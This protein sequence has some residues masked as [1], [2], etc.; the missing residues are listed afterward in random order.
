MRPNFEYYMGK[1]DDWPFEVGVDLSLR[2]RAPIAEK[3]YRIH[4]RFELNGASSDGLSTKEEDALLALIEDEVIA[5]LDPEIYA[6]VSEV[7]HRKAR[8][9]VFYSSQRPEED[10]TIQKALD[11]IETHTTKVIGEEDPE[12]TEYTEVLYPCEEMMHQ[13][14]DKRVLRQFER[15]GDDSAEVRAIEPR[16]I[17]LN[18]ANAKTLAENLRGQGYGIGEIAD[19]GS[20]TWS[21][22]AQVQSPLALAILDDFRHT[23]LELARQHEGTYQGWSAEVVP[24]SGKNNNTGLGGHLNDI[25]DEFGLPDESK[26]SDD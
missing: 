16:F 18:E 6:F 11:L 25:P 13:I 24:V 23:W 8:T 15:Q 7:T 22:T 12:W 21:V 17:G 1:L 2:E 14:Q 26:L 9:L 20:G 3:P 19:S 10:P 4:V 5:T